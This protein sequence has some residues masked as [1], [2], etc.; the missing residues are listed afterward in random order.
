MPTDDAP[1]TSEWSAILLPTTVHLILEV[2]WYIT[3]QIAKTIRSMSIRYRSD[4]KMWDQYLIKVNARVFAIQVGG[5]CRSHNSGMLF[6][7]VKSL[8]FIWEIGAVSILI[9]CLASIGIP[10]LKIRQSHYH[11]VF[12]LGIPIPGKDSLYIEKGPYNL[13]FHYYYLIFR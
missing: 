1:T 6:F 11:L 5:H 7:A 8:Q 13:R 12:N 9:Y 3:S 2:W 4:A 10:M